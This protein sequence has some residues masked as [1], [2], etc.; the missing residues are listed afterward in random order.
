[1][2]IIYIQLVLSVA[3]KRTVEVD[4]EKRLNAKLVL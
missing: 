3:H 4:Q 2:V 1:M